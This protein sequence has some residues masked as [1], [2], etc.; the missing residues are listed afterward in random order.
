MCHKVNEFLYDLNSLISNIDSN[1]DSINEII[2]NFIDDTN[3]N[4]D[5]K[6]ELKKL[7]VNDFLNSMNNDKLI[8]KDEIEK[9]KEKTIPEVLV[10]LVSFF[11]GEEY[12]LENIKELVDYIEFKKLKNLVFQTENIETLENLKTK[13]SK[14]IDLKN[15]FS[16]EVKELLELINNKIDKIHRKEGKNSKNFE[17]KIERDKLIFNK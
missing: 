14:N 3:F 13:I 7:R 9:L 4:N 11:Y 17:K 2:L 1:I 12:N 6:I 16:Y 15:R 10:K 8:Y 5:E